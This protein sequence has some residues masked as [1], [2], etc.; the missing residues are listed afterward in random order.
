M[1]PFALTTEKKSI[2][3]E[4]FSET[5]KNGKYTQKKELAKKLGTA[6]SNLTDRKTGQDLPSCETFFRLCILLEESADYLLGLDRAGE[7]KV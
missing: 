5:M 7:R 6:E 1:R 2:F 4:R 3:P